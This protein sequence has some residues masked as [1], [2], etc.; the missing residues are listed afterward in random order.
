MN[1]MEFYEANKTNIVNV[2]RPDHPEDASGWAGVRRAS[3]ARFVAKD[4]LVMTLADACDFAE[5]YHAYKSGPV[6]PGVDRPYYEFDSDNSRES[7]MPKSVN[8]RK[9]P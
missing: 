1:A 2:P 9:K 8:C 5:K 7:K 4:C 6:D 3:E